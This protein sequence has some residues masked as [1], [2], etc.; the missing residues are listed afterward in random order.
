M[1]EPTVPDLNDVLAEVNRLRA[2][3]DLPPLTALPC[4]H[5]GSAFGCPVAR[6]LDVMSVVPSRNHDGYYRKGLFDDP[7]ELPR[8]LNDFAEA[9]DAGRYPDL[10]ERGGGR[11]LIDAIESAREK[12]SA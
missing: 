4:G 12:V 6:A 2:D 5:P 9:F 11:R 7:V 1:A 8:V 3:D 10:V